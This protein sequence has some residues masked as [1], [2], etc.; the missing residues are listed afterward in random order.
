MRYAQTGDLWWKSAVI[1]C[2]EVKTFADSNG[3]GRGDLAGMTD[4]IE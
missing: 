3:D 4:R 1:Y 2:A